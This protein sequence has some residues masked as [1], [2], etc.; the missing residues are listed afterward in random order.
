[1]RKH[2][3]PFV[4]QPSG[5]PDNRPATAPPGPIPTPGQADAS[6][7]EGSTADPRG[8]AADETLDPLLVSTPASRP[9]VRRVRSSPGSSG[10]R[11]KTTWSEWEVLHLHSTVADPD[12]ADE[13]HAGARR[14][15]ARAPDAQRKRLRE[16]HDVRHTCRL[17]SFFRTARTAASTPSR[18]ARA[19]RRC[20]RLARCSLVL[21]RAA[22]AGEPDPTPPLVPPTA[23]LALGDD[24]MPETQVIEPMLLPMLERSLDPRATSGRPSEPSTTPR[25]S[26][27]A[28]LAGPAGPFSGPCGSGRDRFARVRAGVRPLRPPTAFRDRVRPRTRI[29]VDDAHPARASIRSNAVPSLPGTWHSRARWLRRAPAPDRSIPGLV[30]GRPVGACSNRAR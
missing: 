5:P 13:V 23:P 15:R 3:K 30:P 7:T 26:P 18:I 16:A 11:P 28:T 6:S 27:I 17:R 25:L 24:G 12:R 1:M 20:R 29:R 9:T 19:A 2:Q 8:L 21:V 10:R 22:D 4:Q 14:H